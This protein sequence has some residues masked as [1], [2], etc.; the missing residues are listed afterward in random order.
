MGFLRGSASFILIALGSAI[1][2]F[3]FVVAFGWGRK[4]L[5]IES[6]IVALAGISLVFA[7]YWLVREMDGAPIAV[8]CL[9]VILGAGS[10]LLLVGVLA[11][12]I[13]PSDFPTGYFLLTGSLSVIGFFKFR[14]HIS[15]L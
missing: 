15:R 8:V 3:G 11:L 6:T 4:P 9:K 1:F 10:F 13:R 2:L 7:G 5:P 12:I 14:A